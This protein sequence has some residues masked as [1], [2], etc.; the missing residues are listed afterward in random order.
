MRSLHLILRKQNLGRILAQ[1]LCLLCF[2][3][4][5][6]PDDCPP[7]ERGWFVRIC[8][9]K[10]E[11]AGVGIELGLGGASQKG[12]RRFWRYWR[13]GQPT[14]FGL[15]DDRQD[16]WHA[17]KI[18]MQGDNLTEGKNVYI[19]L[20][21]NDHIVKHYDFDGRNEDHEKIRTDTDEWKCP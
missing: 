10:T 6:S 5:A 17:R 16:L 4:A 7:V 8:E 9:A 21:F 15:P 12:T 13:H 11:A 14:E 18:W 1:V 20:G 3:A 19:G 2:S